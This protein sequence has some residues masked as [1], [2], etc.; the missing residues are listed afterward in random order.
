MLGKLDEQ[1]IES[2]TDVDRESMGDGP[3]VMYR[4]QISARTGRFEKQ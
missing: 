3:A 2:S 1:Q 4:I